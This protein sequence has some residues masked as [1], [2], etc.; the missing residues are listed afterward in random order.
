MLFETDKQCDSDIMIDSF[1]KKL[2]LHQWNI[3]QENLTS[4]YEIYNHSQND[5][6][7]MKKAKFNK[8]S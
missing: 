1:T 6:K 8:I 4:G 5:D 3:Y 2:F 7:M